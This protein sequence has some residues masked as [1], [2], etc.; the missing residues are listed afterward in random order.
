MKKDF[1]VMV[2]EDQKDQ[3]YFVM[4]VLTASGYDVV[5]ATGGYHAL[6]L[7]ERG[8][9]PDLM[10]TDLKM[11]HLNG[12]ELM[13]KLK[14]RNIHLETIVISASESHNDLESA[15]I[16]GV[17]QYLVKPISPGRLVSKVNEIF[18]RKFNG[19]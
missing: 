11:P 19:Q 16:R 6:E 9:R 12:F 2:V 5:C 4:N 8:I 13:E 7:I 14:L 1:L 15:Y 3:A 17:K 10:M 18:G